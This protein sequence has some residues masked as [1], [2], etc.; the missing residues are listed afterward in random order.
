MAVIS[1]VEGGFL[2][3]A[4]YREK[5]A[6]I[7]TLTQHSKPLARIDPHLQVSSVV[8]APLDVLP[9]RGLLLIL[10]G[11]ILLLLPIALQKGHKVPE[12]RGEN[13]E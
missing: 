6:Q 4:A 3:V 8:E 9:R 13:S 12:E 1:T 10:F 11:Q 2:R 7:W 5:Q